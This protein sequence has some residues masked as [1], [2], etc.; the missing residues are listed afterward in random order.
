MQNYILTP[1]STLNL[2]RRTDAFRG[3]R[4]LNPINAYLF[5]EDLI[6]SL[7]V[8]YD[9]LKLKARFARAEK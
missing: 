6:Y 7:H 4:A 2:T 5:F 8:I 3:D 1:K 9:W